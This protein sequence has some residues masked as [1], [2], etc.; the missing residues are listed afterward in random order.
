MAMNPENLDPRAVD[1]VREQIVARGVTDP[2]VLAAMARVPRAAFVPEVSQEKAY[3]DR[4]LP[5]GCEQTISQPY[6]V[7]HMTE[8][9]RLTPTSR[10]LEIGTGSGYQT[11]VLAAL[12]GRVVSVERHA[13]L[14]DRAG[15][16][17]AALGY[18]NVALYT[19]D[20]SAGLP[21]EGPYDAI[22]VTA[23]APAL[24]E[25]LV[26]QLAEGGRLVCPV[27]P[28]KQQELLVITR[29]GSTFERETGTRCMFVPLVGTSGWPVA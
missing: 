17:L 27:G 9:L 29:R 5:I 21:A 26:G 16:Q 3:E 20:G 13:A 6:M 12:A 1:M 22:L 4:P 10:V 25:A 24:P 2:R 28:R 15:T 7:A 11:A 19:G 14:S 8:L 23:G 18:Q